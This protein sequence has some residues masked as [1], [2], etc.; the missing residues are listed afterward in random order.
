MISAS[1]SV[2]LRRTMSPIWNSW[3]MLVPWCRMREVVGRRSFRPL[4]CTDRLHDRDRST[5]GLGMGDMEMRAAELF[6][7]A[8]HGKLPISAERNSAVMAM[9]LD[10]LPER[11]HGL[12]PP[13]RRDFQTRRSEE[14]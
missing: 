7:I 6:S 1:C 8:V 2:P 13:S 10:L 11:L 4:D 3:V 14:H 5:A 9:D 12:P